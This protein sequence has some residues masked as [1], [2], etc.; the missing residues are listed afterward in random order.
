MNVGVHMCV[1]LNDVFHNIGLGWLLNPRLSSLEIFCS[2]QWTL[3]FLGAIANVPSHRT[4]SG[5]GRGPS[6]PT[7]SPFTV[8]RQSG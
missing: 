8:C 6:S 3:L 5:G 7:L 2:G 4:C 1:I